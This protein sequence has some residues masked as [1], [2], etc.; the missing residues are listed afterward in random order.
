M[1]K[2]FPLFDDKLF[3]TKLQNN[4]QYYS[5]TKIDPYS[6]EQADVARNLVDKYLFNA[7][8]NYIFDCPYPSSKL[9]L[10]KIEIFEDETSGLDYGL[11][12]SIDELHGNA[13]ENKFT[14]KIEI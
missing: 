13:W 2:F 1:T 3:L 9:R 5:Y 10:P 7:E 4:Y 6:S 14:I 12:D 11:L 8:G